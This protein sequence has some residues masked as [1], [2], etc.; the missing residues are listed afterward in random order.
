M[1]DRELDYRLGRLVRAATECEAAFHAAAA[2]VRGEEARVA[3]LERAAGFGGAART[4]RELG[5][6]RGLLP[7]FTVGR[8]LM[9]RGEVSSADDATIL[10]RCERCEDLTA[11]AFRDLL[12]LTLP[13]T[14]RAALEPEFDR[15]L[16]RLGRLRALRERADRRREPSQAHRV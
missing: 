15:L 5:R 13:V 2:A 16:A 9:G 6:S 4:L 10:A 12:D 8:P 1:D 11:A 3:L 14:M 7:P